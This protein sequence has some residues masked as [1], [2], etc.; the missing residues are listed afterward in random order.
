MCLA[1]GAKDV[2]I[3]TDILAEQIQQYPPDKRTPLEAIENGCGLSLLTFTKV[4]RGFGA[5]SANMF[6]R[7]AY[8][9]GR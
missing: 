2:Y 5:D 6:Q 8:V 1:P 4:N 3:F 9:T 7:Y